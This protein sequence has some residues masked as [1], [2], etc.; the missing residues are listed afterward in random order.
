MNNRKSNREALDPPLTPNRE[1]RMPILR[2]LIEVGGTAE[3]KVVLDRVY[4]LMGD[5]LNSSDY[6][7]I[8]SGTELRWRKAANWERYTMMK[9]G[10]IK[11]GSPQGIWEIT[12]Y[13]EEY[14][15][16]HKS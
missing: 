15:N 11:E 12:L 14:Y 10:L 5:R 3:C 9:D 13:G 6:S 4:E 7:L 16:S 2:V 1:Y 8:P